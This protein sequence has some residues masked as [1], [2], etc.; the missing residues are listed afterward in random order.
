MEFIKVKRQDTDRIRAIA[1]GS[2]RYWGYDDAFMEKFNT[3]YNITADFVSSN[4]VYAGIENDELI[5]FWGLEQS[6]TAAELAYFYV[7][8]DR[9]GGGAGRKLWLHFISWCREHRVERVRWVTG[10]RAAGFYRRMGAVQQEDVFSPIDGRPIPSFTCEISSVEVTVYHYEAF[11]AVPGKGN[12]AGVVLAADRLDDGQMQA[13]AARMGFNET[14]FVL[15]SESADILLRYFT[16]GQEMNLCGHATVAS[17]Y[18]MYERDL[19]SGKRNITV[20]TK[21]GILPLSIEETD[22]GVMIHMTQAAPSFVEY[23]GDRGELAAVLG[24]GQEEIDDTLPLVY[25]STGTWTLLVPVRGLPVFERMEPRNEM[26]P[27]VLGQMPRS[28]VHPFCFEAFGK[29]CQVH[30]RHFSSPYSGTTEDPVTGTASGV[31][32]CYYVTYVEPDSESCVLKMEQGHEMG[33]DGEVLVRVEK[34]VEEMSVAIA[35]T[36]VFV[37]ETNV[38]V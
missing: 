36:A 5:C 15:E 9:I 1:E 31:I 2:E 6:G 4:P 29:G 14:A 27:A 17:V 37:K 3:D 10:R 21:A 38:N 30:S 7:A 33:R 8:S 28:S 19:L 16:P 22:A 26:F 11:S 23:E 13:V 35:G 34:R 32:G 20:E 25:G 12:P 24:I 18:G